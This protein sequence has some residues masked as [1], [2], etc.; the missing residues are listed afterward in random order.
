MWLSY[1]HIH[2]YVYIPIYTHI[3]I[4]AD[5]YIIFIPIITSP[6]GCENATHFISILMHIFI[7]NLCVLFILLL[8]KLHTQDRFTYLSSLPFSILSLMIISYSNLFRQN[9][10]S[11]LIFYWVTPCPNFLTSINTSRKFHCRIISWGNKTQW[12]EHGVK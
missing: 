12:K 8:G 4:F 10:S 7:L 3:H 9:C 6:S 2:I 5:M 11:V 1:I